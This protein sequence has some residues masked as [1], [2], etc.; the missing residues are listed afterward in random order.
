MIGRIDAKTLQ[1]NGESLDFTL[2]LAKP[3]KEKEVK[4]EELAHKMIQRNN[5]G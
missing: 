2:S 5:L 3:E 1:E 4:Y